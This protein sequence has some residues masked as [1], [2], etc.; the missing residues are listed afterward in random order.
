MGIRF[1][2]TSIG[3]VARMRGEGCSCLTSSSSCEDESD[4]SLG[5]LDSTSSE[6]ELGDEGLWPLG[7]QLPRPDSLAFSSSEDELGD[8]GLRPL[9]EQL[10]R[11]DSLAFA[12]TSKEGET[13]LPLNCS[14]SFSFW[15]GGDSGSL[16]ASSSHVSTTMFGLSPGR[17]FLAVC[18]V[19]VMAGTKGYNGKYL[20]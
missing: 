1:L 16:G 15:A 12:S 5:W 6:D 8:E 9:G 19:R 20:W 11:P 18:L 2:G 7:E 10:P 13:E 4:L 14:S 17:A 3:V